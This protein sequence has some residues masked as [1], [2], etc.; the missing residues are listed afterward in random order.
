MCECVYVNT[1]PRDIDGVILKKMI[2]LSL[3]VTWVCP[4]AGSFH[5][6]ASKSKGPYPKSYM[7]FFP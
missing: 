6:G 4:N 2:M 3:S 7:T 5:N 1:G